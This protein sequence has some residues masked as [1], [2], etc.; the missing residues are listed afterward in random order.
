MIGP[1]RERAA[2][3]KHAIVV[4][5]FDDSEEFALISGIAALSGSERLR[6]KSDGAFDRIA[7]GGNERL[8]KDSAESDF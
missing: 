5:R 6:I 3:Q 1:D 7:V 2:E 4:R 8:F